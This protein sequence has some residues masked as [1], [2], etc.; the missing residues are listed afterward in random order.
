MIDTGAHM[1]DLLVASEGRPHLRA[2]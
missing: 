1:A 2:V